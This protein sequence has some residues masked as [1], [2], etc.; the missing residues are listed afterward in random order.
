MAE[1]NAV[2]M[3]KLS[4]YDLKVQKLCKETLELSETMP[5]AAVVDILKSVVKTLTMNKQPKD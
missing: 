2:I 5:T 1:I 3:K 4:E